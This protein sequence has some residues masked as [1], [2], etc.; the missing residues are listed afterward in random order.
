MYI[1]FSVESAALKK[2]KSLCFVSKEK[3]LKSGGVKSSDKNTMKSSYG[4]ACHYGS[5]HEGTRFFGVII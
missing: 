2:S 4:I 3:L 1:M 5:E